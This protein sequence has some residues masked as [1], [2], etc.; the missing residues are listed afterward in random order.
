MTFVIPIDSTF[1]RRLAF[2]AYEIEEAYDIYVS[3]PLG[4]LIACGA[5]AAG[6]SPNQVT[7]AG[8]VVG[9]VAGLLF[10]DVAWGGLGFTLLLVHGIVD[11]A[12]GQLA[13]L[14]GRTSELGRMLDGAAGYVTHVVLY[15]AIAAGTVAAGGTPAVWLLAVAAGVSTIAH[16]QMYD[17]HRTAYIDVVLKGRVPRPNAGRRA[18]SWVRAV[19]RAYDA[20]QRLLVGDHAQVEAALARRA[21]GGPVP[22]AERER[23]RQRFYTL[24]RGWNALG[25]NGRRFA[26]GVAAIAGRLTWYFWFE[27]IVMNLVLAGLWTWQRRADRLFLAER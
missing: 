14:T 19:L 25:D 4:G 2:K 18:P 9:V 26:V 21:A 3:R 15:A 23:Y 20:S 16:A 17:Y 5:R 7:V 24:V 1:R 11:S 10:Y 13:R 12:D 22:D 6:L 27:A 8:A